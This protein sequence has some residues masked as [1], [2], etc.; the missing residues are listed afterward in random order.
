MVLEKHER[1]GHWVQA[2]PLLMYIDT[3]FTG[4]SE[5]HQQNQLFSSENGWGI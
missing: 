1:A 4:V 3:I 5:V 2:L